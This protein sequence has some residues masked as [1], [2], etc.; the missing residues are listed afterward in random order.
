M[1]TKAPLNVE[2]WVD[3]QVDK[4]KEMGVIRESPSPWFA[5]VVVV[6][7]KSGDIRLC[8]DFRRLNSLTIK[9]IYSI[10]DTQK[11]TGK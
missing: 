10:P 1:K 6:K 4:L 5:P 9:T 11:R 7:K 2:D 3:N 8:I